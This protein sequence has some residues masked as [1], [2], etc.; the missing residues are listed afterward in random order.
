LRLDCFTP[1]ARN[2]RCFDCIHDRDGITAEWR[3][4]VAN[5]LQGDFVDMRCQPAPEV[6]PAACDSDMTTWPHPFPLTAP[7][8]N[9]PGA[10]GF[11]VTP[12]GTI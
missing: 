3:A 10:V 1:D 4:L 6:G 8:L 9:L 5:F 12:V 2:W 7:P 11:P